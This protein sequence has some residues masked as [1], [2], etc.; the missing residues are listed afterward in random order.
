MHTVSFDQ[1]HSPA[2]NNSQIYVRLLNQENIFT[3]MHKKTGEGTEPA[4][5]VA[6]WRVF[7]PSA[8]RLPRMMAVGTWGLRVPWFLQCI[9]TRPADSEVKYPN[10]QTLTTSLAPV[11]TVESQVGTSVD[12]IWLFRP[13]SLWLGLCTFLVHLRE[14]MALHVTSPPKA[15]GCILILIT[16]N[17]VWYVSG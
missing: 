7:A 4:G 16:H 2:P 14:E 17:H 5:S 15:K 6:F 10:I 11:V 12:W 1:T 9:I 8:L 3:V 13:L